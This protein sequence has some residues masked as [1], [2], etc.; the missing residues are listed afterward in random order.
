[1]ETKTVNMNSDILKGVSYRV[2]MEDVDENT[3]INQ[4]VKLGVMWYAANLYKIGKITLSDAAE[5]S[6][7]SKRKMLDMLEEYGIKGNVSM[8][9]QIKALEYAKNL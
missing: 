4:L 3:A 2:K 7:V 5:L 6:N 1:M 9:Q 8:K